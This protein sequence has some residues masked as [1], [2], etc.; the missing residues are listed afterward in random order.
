MTEIMTLPTDSKRREKKIMAFRKLMLMIV[1]ILLVLPVG[2]FSAIEQDQPLGFEV[3]VLDQAN[4]GAATAGRLYIFP[5]VVIDGRSLIGAPEIMEFG[6]LAQGV[7]DGPGVRPHIIEFN[8]S[9]THAVISNVT[10]GHVYFMRTSDRAIVGSIDVGLQ[11]HHAH[12]SVDETMALVAK[13]NDKKLG[14]IRTNYAMDSFTYNPAEDLDLGAL[15][16]AG[17]PDNAPICPVLVGGRAFVTLRGGG[18]YIVNTATMTITKSFTRDEIAPAGCGAVAV[19]GKV[20]INSG[21]ATT[22]HL[23]VFDAATEALIKTLNLTGRGTDAHGMALTGDGRYLWMGHRGDGDNI[24]VIDTATDEVIDQF[25]D[26]GAA[27]D[28]MAP[29]PSG[30]LVF[31]TLRGPNNLTGGPAAKGT[32]PGLAVLRVLQDGAMGQIGFFAP[33]GS[34]AADSPNDPHGVAVRLVNQ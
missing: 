10:S 7:G 8:H 18:L 25:S 21:T 9:Q 1:T 15:Q 30:D 27:P 11:A 5:G 20:Y 28:L 3:W 31:V 33:I 6:L 2:A 12:P 14:V 32:T 23:Y 19:A 29:S 16:D 26:F 13:Q 24:V 22:S 34:Q 4:V 17:H